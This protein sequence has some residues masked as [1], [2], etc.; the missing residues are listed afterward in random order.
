MCLAQNVQVLH[1]D[2]WGAPILRLSQYHNPLQCQAEQHLISPNL[3]SLCGRSML[4]KSYQNQQKKVSDHKIQTQVV[5]AAYRPLAIK[6][7]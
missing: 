2:K 7:T 1:L 5:N 6:E 3:G 4:H